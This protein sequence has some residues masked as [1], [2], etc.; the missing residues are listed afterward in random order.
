MTSNSYHTSL[1]AAE[2]A[3][4]G[5]LLRQPR[6][7]HDVDLD[8]Q[9]FFSPHCRRIHEAICALWADGVEPDA[10]AVTDWTEKQPGVTVEVVDVLQLEDAA[11]MSVHLPTTIKLIHESALDRKVRLI[12][13]GLQKSDKR[14]GDLWTEAMTAF[15]DAPRME[16]KGPVRLGDAV[17][18]ILDDMERREKG[19][20]G[21]SILTGVKAIDELNLLRRGGVM[22]I[23]GYTSMGKT[24]FVQYL[25][26]LWALNGEKVLVFSTETSHNL[27]ARRSLSR[28]TQIN[29]RDF[30]RTGPASP[31][32]WR[33]VVAGASEL[34][35]Q[36]IWIDDESDRVETITRAIRRERQR[37]GITIVI[38]D[39]IGECIPDIEPRKEINQLISGCKKACREEPKTGLVLLSQLGRKVEKRPDRRPR[40]SDMLESSKIEAASDSIA[41]LHRPHYYLKEGVQYYVGL[42]KQGKSVDP[43]LLL[44]DI[45]KNRDDSTCILPMAW[46]NHRGQVLGPRSSRDVA[47]PTELNFGDGYAAG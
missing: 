8:S 33:T 23:A 17:T 31:S 40:K 30:L 47:P 28:E 26:R 16:S 9:E 36:D 11:E 18:E 46:D 32:T 19:D 20:T 43:G 14:G 4:V 35:K 29:T 45:P 34:A 37:L 1:E 24:S 22:T 7:F 13:K 42:E 6:L 44:I 3:L 15:G 21:S 10:I 38:V 5:A 25:A 2:S 27:M 41:L 39:Y 12:A